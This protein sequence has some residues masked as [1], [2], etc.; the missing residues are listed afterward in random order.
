MEFRKKFFKERLFDVNG[1]RA[2]ARGPVNVG[3]G[4]VFARPGRNGIPAQREKKTSD[5]TIFTG[6]NYVC[7][8]AERGPGLWPEGVSV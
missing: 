1:S 7:G 6:Q 3:M 4:P 5:S 8:P 2:V